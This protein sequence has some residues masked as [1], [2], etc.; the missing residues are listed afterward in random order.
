MLHPL[1]YRSLLL[2]PA[3]F[4]LLTTGCKKAC[5]GDNLPQYTLTAGQR[6]WGAPFAENAVWRFRNEATGYERTY[7]VTKFRA[8]SIGSGGAAKISVCPSYYQDYVFAD[9]ERT[10]STFTGSAKQ[11]Y[12][13]QLTA[14]NAGNTTGDFLQW[15]P[16]AAF[17]LPIDATESGQQVLLPATFGGRSYPAVLECTRN[18][19]PQP[20]VPYPATSVR[21]FLTKA[22][23]LV[24]FEERGGNVW[25]RL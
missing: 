16:A 22:E 6:A 11:I 9:L 15:G 21:L 17:Y 19:A 24:R 12:H 25:N 14:P 23:G 5:D 7:R 18:T 20:T 13:L 2:L 4:L 8:E 1:S 3:V 10:D